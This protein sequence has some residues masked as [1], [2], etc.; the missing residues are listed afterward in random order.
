LHG[1]SH[2]DTAVHAMQARIAGAHQGPLWSL[3]WHPEGH[4]LA[5]GGGDS[6]AK[7]WCR[8]RPGDAFEEKFADRPAGMQLTGRVVLP[9]RSHVQAGAPHP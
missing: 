4:L 8:S 6:C 1:R 9:W 2:S 7:F 5:S 3:A